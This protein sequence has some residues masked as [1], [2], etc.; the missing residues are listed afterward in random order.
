[1]RPIRGKQS[2]NAVFK[3]REHMAC[4]KSKTK[5]TPKRNSKKDTDNDGNTRSSKY[6]GGIGKTIM[7]YL[8]S[9]SSKLVD[10]TITSGCHGIPERCFKVKGKPM[11]FCARCLGV[12]I[13]HTAALGFLFLGAPPLSAVSLL[14]LAVVL[15]GLMFID[16]GL[17]AFAAIESNNPRRLVSGICG[18]SGFIFFIWGLTILVSGFVS[19]HIN[20]LM[21]R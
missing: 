5:N 1:M 6:F 19:P 16:W 11:P 12:G 21:Q 8:R 7:A 10:L 20:Y 4:S 18:G 17:Q 2:Y 15:L 13:G 3:V 9:F 14:I